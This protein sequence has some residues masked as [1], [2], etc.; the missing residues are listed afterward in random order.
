MARS[1]RTS[2]LYIEE[3]LLSA[4]NTIAMVDRYPSLPDGT[5]G[6]GRGFVAMFLFLNFWLDFCRTSFDYS[7]GPRSSVVPCQCG[8]FNFFT[9]GRH[10]GG[11]HIQFPSVFFVGVSLFPFVHFRA[12]SNEEF[13]PISI[14][15]RNRGW[16]WALQK[17]R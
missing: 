10:L 8:G 3:R 12:K 16:L 11:E 17:R 2:T 7:M 9:D 5:G 6:A 4:L 1:V 15:W 13:A 14:W